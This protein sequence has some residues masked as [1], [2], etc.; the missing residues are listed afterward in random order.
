L[1]RR[2]MIAIIRRMAA[3]RPPIFALW[4][5]FF[6][7]S[8]VPILWEHKRELLFP[9]VFSFVL[10]VGWRLYEKCFGSETVELNARQ[11]ITKT[12]WA[13]WG[14]ICAVTAQDLFQISW[15]HPSKPQMPS[16]AI[17]LRY[18]VFV[19]ILATFT[20]FVAWLADTRK[21][22]FITLFG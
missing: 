1:N 2:F 16:P 12:F 3:K 15:A 4:L 22:P 5:S 19:T 13:A 10:A 7:L 9:V 21:P 17:V 20:T 6:V 11:R 18:I 14:L 8:S